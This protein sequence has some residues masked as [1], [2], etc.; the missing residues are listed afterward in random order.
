MHVANYLFHKHT[1]NR[2]YILCILGYTKIA[3]VYVYFEIY[4]LYHFF[5]YPTI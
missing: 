2:V 1:K 4:K 3:N 5:V